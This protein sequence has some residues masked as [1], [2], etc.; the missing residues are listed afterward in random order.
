MHYLLRYTYVSDVATRRAPYRAAHLKALWD[1]ADAGRIVLAGGAGDPMSEGVIVFDVD[2]AQVVHDFAATD[3][4][5]EAGLIE[6][7][8]VVPWHTVVGD[9]A[10]NPTRPDTN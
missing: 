2:D 8:S 6:D 1:E 5:R 9:L 7:Y 4:Y 3:P 10:H